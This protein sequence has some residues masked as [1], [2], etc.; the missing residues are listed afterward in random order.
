MSKDRI[1]ALF[2][3]FQ[4]LLMDQSRGEKQ[5]TFLEMDCVRFLYH[6][7]NN[8]YVVLLTTKR[9]NI[10]RD[11]DSHF[12]SSSRIGCERNYKETIKKIKKEKHIKQILGEDP[13]HGYSLEEWWKLQ[14]TPN[15]SQKTPMQVPYEFR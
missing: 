11:M 12:L 14:S 1:T 10:L 3:G 5:Y 4:S 2:Y 7:L 8:V 9:S 6:M 13:A 15:R